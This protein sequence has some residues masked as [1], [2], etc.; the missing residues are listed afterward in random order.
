MCACVWA[1]RWGYDREVADSISCFNRHYAERS[2]AWQLHP[3]FVSALSTDQEITFYDSVSGLPVFIA[4]RGR[5]MQ[6]FLAETA[7]HGWPS[8]RDAEVRLSRAK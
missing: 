8:F 7:A 2:G 3:A 1:I 4:P 6:D 5:S